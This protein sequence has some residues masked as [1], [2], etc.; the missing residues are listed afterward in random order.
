MVPLPHLRGSGKIINIVKTR[1]F[2]NSEHHMVYHHGM[3]G[4]GKGEPGSNHM[5]N[6]LTVSIYMHWVRRIRLL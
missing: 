2:S 3:G 5:G 6:S 1:N 4:A